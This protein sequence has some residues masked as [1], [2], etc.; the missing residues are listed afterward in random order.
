VN[1]I[2]S[3]ISEAFLK[4]FRSAGKF[5][6]LLCILPIFLGAAITQE[7]AIRTV[8]LKIAID[9]N[10]SSTKM[11]RSKAESMIERTSKIYEKRFGIKLEI[12]EV[13]TWAPD[14]SIQSLND[15]LNDLRSKVPK[16]DCDIVAG[17]ISRYKWRSIR[18]GVASYLTGY[19]IARD[20]RPS[21]LT[22][23]AVLHELCHLF[24]GVD[25]NE[26]GSYMSMRLAGPKFDKFTTQVP[27]AN[28]MKLSLCTT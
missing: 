19:M 26:P 10:F 12:K 6:F 9:Q 16:G 28:W 13:E 22:R 11:W 14:T 25:I 1:H 2:C 4:G 27:K 18:F 7:Q 15:S 23:V 5:F 3:L 20:M 8:T 21:S 24:G 17:F